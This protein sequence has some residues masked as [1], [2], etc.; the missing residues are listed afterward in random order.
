MERKH[1]LDKSAYVGRVRVSYTVCS[2]ERK[3][4]FRDETVV[5]VFV[6]ILKT[7]TAKY[8][9]TNWIYVFMPDHAHFVLEGNKDDSDSLKAMYMF[10]QKAGYWL[11]VNKPGC[12]MQKDFFDRIH[13]KD[14]DL[15]F[16]MFYI[17]QNPVRAGLVEK[18][19]DYKHTGSVSVDLAV[20]MQSA[21]GLLK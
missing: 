13:R 19:E 11:K 8:N 12:N 10:K 9:L 20:E 21:G 3:P 14:E 18:W 6:N 15:V 1:R 2:E 5:N 7:I 4:I 17:A 16:Q